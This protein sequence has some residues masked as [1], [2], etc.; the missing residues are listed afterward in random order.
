MRTMMD[1]DEYMTGIGRRARQASR[2]MARAA[3][4]AKND[5]LIAIAHAIE[6]EAAALKEANARDV[7]GAREKG[8]DAAFVDR[9]TLSDKALSTMV[10]GLRQV[11]ALADPIGEISNLKYRPSGI[12]VG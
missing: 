7:A 4:A 5:A 2:A 11:A 10:E 8:L 1:I 12:Q 3:T 6:R 9:L